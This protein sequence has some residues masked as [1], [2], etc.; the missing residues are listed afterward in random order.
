MIRCMRLQRIG[1]MPKMRR[2]LPAAMRAMHTARRDSHAC[3]MS[4]LLLFLVRGPAPI[5]V[6]LSLLLVTGLPPAPPPHASRSGTELARKRIVYR[7]RLLEYDK[8][9]AAYESLARPY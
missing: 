2:G 4:E 1:G 5:V 7:H 9:R 8:A 6:L 3:T